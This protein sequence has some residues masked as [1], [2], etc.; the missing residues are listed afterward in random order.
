MFQP[1][2][3]QETLRLT[4]GQALIKFLQVQF[5]EFDGEVQRFHS[6][7]LGHLRPWQ[8]QWLEPGALGIR[9]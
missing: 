9:R 3:R 1:F 7:H 2:G 6:R 8:R 5:T 4:M